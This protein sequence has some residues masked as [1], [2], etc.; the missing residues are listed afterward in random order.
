MKISLITPA[1]KQSKSGN[2]TT[3]VRWARF[4]RDLGHKVHVDTD[5]HNEPADMMVAL[6]AWRTASSS[7]R[8]RALYP[9]RPLVVALTG[10][11][12]NEYIFTD[13]DPTLKSME[14]ADALVCLHDLA[15][16][17]TPK[18]FHKKLTVI[19]QSCPPL[20]GPRRPSQRYFDICVIGHLR[21]V[22]DPLRAALAVR[23]LP[24]SSRI[25]LIQLGHAHT[26]AW[27]D[28]ARAEEKKNPRFSWKGEVPF[29]RVRREF[30]KTQLM[31]ISSLNEG[32]ANVVSEAIVAGVPVI[33]SDIPGNVGLLGA[34]YPGY[35]PVKNT[36]AL[37]KL[38]LRTE[39]EP[40]FLAGLAQH[41]QT[42]A[43]M[44]RPEHEQS[45]WKN[46]IQRL[47]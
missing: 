7:H 13:P 39:N 37:K 10:T 42:R 36:A 45:S 28:T 8:F 41:C 24:H 11:D 25:R 5:Y 19:Y 4:M 18:R 3:A 30:Q 40:A 38:L 16:G 33:A 21:D 20:P 46:V 27:A 22:K 2:R 23:N 32:G 44:F 14:I 12:I 1:N 43:P 15:V 6:H 17:A 47:S 35:F 26:A 9:N 34:G 31:V 29:G